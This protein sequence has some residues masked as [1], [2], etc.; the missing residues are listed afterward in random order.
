M[1]VPADALLRRTNKKNDAL[2]REVLAQ[3]NRDS[4]KAKKPNA[5]SLGTL[6][7]RLR[8]G[9]PS[10]W[11]PRPEPTNILANIAGCSPRALLE[12]SPEP[13]RGVSFADFHELRP[14]AP[15]DDAA[16]R[17][18]GGQQWLAE[19]VEAVLGAECP[20]WII[21]PP[22]SG[23]RLA[24]RYLELR[25]PEI[26]AIEAPILIDV[27]R[28][29]F[30][31]PDRG[32]VA[33]VSRHDGTD[34]VAFAE[35]SSRAAPTVVLAAFHPPV[36]AGP[37]WHVERWSLASDWHEQLAEW[38]VAR[39]N[40]V[41]KLT[42]ETALELLTEVDAGGD[43]IATPGDAMPLL[44]WAS[45][46]DTA[47][48]EIPLAEIGDAL[49][50]ERL[51]RAGATPSIAD[52]AARALRTMVASALDCRVDGHRPRFRADWVGQLP[53]PPVAP[54]NVE[55]VRAAIDALAHAKPSERA[56]L[57]VAAEAAIGGDSRDVFVAAFIQSGLLIE[58]DDGFDVHPRWLRRAYER[59]AITGATRSK[60]WER[61]GRLAAVPSIRFLVLDAVA[62]LTRA[63]LIS[64]A[65]VLFEARERSLA[66]AAAVEVVFET[67]ARLLTPG[68]SDAPWKPG[69]AHLSVLRDL[70]RLQAQ[71]VALRWRS[72]RTNEPSRFTAAP[73][74][75]RGHENAAWLAGAWGFSLVVPVPDEL[76]MEAGWAFPAWG[77]LPSE[78]A[79]LPK[80]EGLRELAA[81]ER[82]AFTRFVAVARRVVRSVPALVHAEA[83]WVVQA[84]AIVEGIALP[85]GGTWDY[86]WW[87]GAADIIEGLATQEDDAKRAAIAS[88]VWRS[89]VHRVDG[90]P[91]ATFS[92]AGP[93]QPLLSQA[94]PSDVFLEGM[95]L[96]AAMNAMCVQ[97]VRVDGL[98]N[99]LLEAFFARIAPELP[100]CR[101][102]A[103]MQ[104]DAAI[105]RLTSIGTLTKLLDAPR[106]C[107]EPAAARLWDLAPDVALA[108]LDR[109]VT[110]NAESA[111]ALIYRSPPNQV[112][113]VLPRALAASEEM[114]IFIPRW[115]AERAAAGGPRADTLFRALMR[116]EGG[117]L[118]QPLHA[119]GATAK[120]AVPVPSPAGMKVS[121]S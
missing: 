21:A 79:R 64:L 99:R 71:L 86:P 58:D 37:T 59:E 19:R 29:S 40:D 68:L 83:P 8:H 76:P 112:D 61:W 78:S 1:T 41:S 44:A 89:L 103:L 16:A 72:T 34:T 32:L 97:K 18:A 93:F 48:A 111:A 120:S 54:G 6:I 104:L 113:A 11:L 30:V 49:V 82:D 13:V 60:D 10:W 77:R 2:A 23:K 27:A 75:S 91:L 4:R 53:P 101:F 52:G 67:L 108:A 66:W 62:L 25:H 88:G 107:A 102:A 24:V 63:Q 87:P 28:S 115:L 121:K 81:S 57:K 26:S 114:S 96:A 38:T 42:V 35:L 106:G 98:P 43:L 36:D 69:A 31:T 47:V 94:L 45:R 109:L 50:R 110:S 70:G 56:D 119:A 39:I 117:L 100:T 80:P 3:W 22:G 9:D 116:R 118:A 20:V 17:V 90:D 15:R 46:N 65:Q 95:N 14:L 105:G 92:I 51:V 33:C 84:A 85:D 5:R 55:A 12:A 73:D 74:E 7:G